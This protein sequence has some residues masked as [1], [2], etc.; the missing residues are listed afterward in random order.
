MRLLC[1]SIV[2]SWTSHLLDWCVYIYWN[3]G[4]VLLVSCLLLKKGRGP[5]PCLATVPWVQLV[6]NKP[7][8]LVVGLEMLVPLVL[9][10]GETLQLLMSLNSS[11]TLSLRH[12][13]IVYLNHARCLFP[14]VFF[15]MSF[16]R[17]LSIRT[18]LSGVGNVLLFL[19][20]LFV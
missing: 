12:S 7:L 3:F 8:A 6:N 14:G 15:L 20:E 2:I 9:A 10:N 11:L 17:L 1:F 5:K 13:L 19:R 4:I 18:S 16:P